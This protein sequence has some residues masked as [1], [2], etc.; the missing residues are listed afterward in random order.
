MSV[1]EHRP[2]RRSE[3]SSTTSERMDFQSEVH[4]ALNSVI[5]FDRHNALLNDT[6]ALFVYVNL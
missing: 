4:G 3:S 1:E 5:F 2:L 6:E